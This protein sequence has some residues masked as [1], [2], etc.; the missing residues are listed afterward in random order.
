MMTDPFCRYEIIV[1]EDFLKLVTKGNRGKRHTITHPTRIH[2]NHTYVAI[3][4]NGLVYSSTWTKQHMHL[5]MHRTILYL[6]LHVD[7][8]VVLEFIRCFVCRLKAAREPLVHG[9]A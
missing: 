8:E 5:H 2:V 3:L 7:L 1:S 6:V 4:I 9:L